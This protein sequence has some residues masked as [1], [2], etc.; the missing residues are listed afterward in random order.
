MFIPEKMKLNSFQDKKLPS[1]RDYFKLTGYQSSPSS[2]YTG[3]EFAPLGQNKVEACESL[4]KHVKSKV[5][6]MEESGDKSNS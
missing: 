3:D 2:G 6:E 4:I 5:S 1:A